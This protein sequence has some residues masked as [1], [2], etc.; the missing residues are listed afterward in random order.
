[1]AEAKYSFNSLME[2]TK[3]PA[4]VFVE[5]HGSWLKDADG[6]EYLD[7]VQGWAVNCLGHSP[8]ALVAAISK[9][10]AKLINCSPAFYNGP[11]IRLADLIVKHSCLQRVF[12]ANSG[13]EANE[14]A[15]KLARK[16]GAKYKN[17]AYEIITMDHAFHGRTLAM[18]S[19]SGKAEWKQLY[20]P[21]VP[22][23]PKAVLNDLE[24]VKALLNEKTVGV[25]LEPIQGEAGVFVATDEFMKGLRDLTREKGILLILDEIQ[26]GMGRM[27]TLFGYE[28]YGIEP[29]IMTL[30]K[31][32][33][34]G[35]PLAALVAKESICVFEVGDQGGTFN[36]NPLMMAVGI[37]VF[38]ELTKPGF[39]ERVV[40]TGAY[41]QGRLE[42]LS[43]Q[44]GLGE[45]RGKGLLWALDL[46]KEIGPQV[47]EECLNRGLLINSP[48]KNTLRF[49]PAL[50]VNRKEV[51]RMMDTL[52]GALQKIG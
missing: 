5:G 41:L 46:N 15:L 22:G 18:M 37:A 14:G 8:R 21:K 20:E 10:A 12:F 17:G 11:M 40:K 50:N 51:D 36:G 31:G 28:Q 2:I 6:K 16:W 4:N 45:V 1:M 30:A 26:T 19:A 7:F 27:G 33:G 52:K 42:D 48:R 3:R 24:S 49:M 32:L 39:L 38:K 25:L 13:A 9:Q 44:Q 34:G 43:R 23:F 47:V 35:V 29:D